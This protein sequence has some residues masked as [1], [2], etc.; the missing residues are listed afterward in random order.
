MENIFYIRT[1]NGSIK[2]TL[3][4]VFSLGIIHYICE[5]NDSSHIL[6]Q[7][8]LWKLELNLELGVR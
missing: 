4:R 6:F 1:G 2:F 8:I 5:E 7:I 3:F